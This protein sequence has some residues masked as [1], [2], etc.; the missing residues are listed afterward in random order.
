MSLAYQISLNIQEVVGAD[1]EVTHKLDL[2]EILDQESMI[3]LLKAALAERGFEEVDEATMERVGDDGVKQSVNLESLEVTSSLEIEKEVSAQVSAVGD[4]ETRA[5]ARRDAE[6][7]AR[8]RVSAVVESGTRDVQREVTAKLE[9]GQSGRIEEL[10]E[11]LQGVY[12]EALKRKAPQ[13][14]EV[15]E[16]REGTN[17]AGDYELTIKVQV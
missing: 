4:G 6:R 9:K 8:D 2:R 3:E 14:G 12:A 10:N 7:R 1:D 11:V 17:A 5:E 15:I 13:M 16:V